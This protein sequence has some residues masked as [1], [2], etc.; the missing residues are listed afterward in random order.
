MYNW[1]KNVQWQP[2]NFFE[3]SSEGEI[4]SIIQKAITDKKKIRIIGSGHSFT[5]LCATD[6]VSISLDNYQ[7]IIEVDKEKCQATVK[8]GTKLFKLGDMLFQHGLAMENLGD[9]DVQSIAGTISTGTHGTG[10]D[11]GTISTQVVG[12]KM[13]NGKG[14]L[15]TCSE[16]INASLFKAAQVSLGSLGVITEVTLQCVPAYRMK[17]ENKKEDLSDVLA[18][19]SQRHKEN[20]NFEFYWI[21]YTKTAWTKSSN[22]VDA[23]V[24]DKVGLMNYYVEYFLENYLFKGFCEL[25]TLF[26]SQNELVAKITAASISNVSKVHNSHKIYATQ[27][28]VRFKEMEYNIPIEVYD[29]VWKEVMRVVNSKK[30]NIHFPIENRVVKQDDILMSPAYGRDSA[31]IAC[32]VYYKKDH[33]PYFKALEEVFR[34]YGGRPHWGKMNSLKA[35]DVVDLYPEFNTFMKHRLEQDPDEV[36]ITPYLRSLLGL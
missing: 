6:D 20:R 2:S 22:V 11:F 19:L 8:G 13:I 1:G 7:G 27:R 15:I 18:S 31:Y 16:E 4:Q 3:P 10:R 25:A 9:I 36:F 5:P 12:L 32:H 28:L 30:Y 17:V 23:E 21:P 26:P 14:E 29:D 35:K 34:A 24:S 33:R